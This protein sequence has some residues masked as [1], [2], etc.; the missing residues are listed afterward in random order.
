MP[1][2][3]RA[4]QPQI[5]GTGLS[6]RP[7]LPLSVPRGTCA[8]LSLHAHEGGGRTV[9]PDTRRTIHLGVNFLVAP[10]QA[11]DPQRFFL[12]Q[13]RLADERIEISQANRAGNQFQLAR[14]TTPQ[15]QIQIGQTAPNTG[16]LLIVSSVE[17]GNPA[18]QAGIVDSVFKEEAAAVVD[19]FRDVWPETQQVLMRDAAIRML[20][21]CGGI[22]AFKYLWEKRLKQP[23]QALKGFGRTIHGGGIRLVFPPTQEHETVTDVKVESFLADPSKLYMEAVIQW[24]N[25][26]PELGDALLDPGPMVE[27]LEQVSDML[28]EFMEDDAS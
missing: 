21:D 18:V 26:K 28:V 4:P 7:L 17:P 27:E 13:Q 12:L 6:R 9:R 14:L 23:E 19:V 25:Q 20:F 11:L 2:V 22:H 5:D 15:L 1:L 10:F 16:Q 8:A 24:E 3:F